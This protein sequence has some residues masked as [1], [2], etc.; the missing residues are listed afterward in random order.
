MLENFNLKYHRIDPRISTFTCRTLFRKDCRILKVMIFSIFASIATVLRQFSSWLI[1]QLYCSVLPDLNFFYIC[2]LPY[3]FIAVWTLKL[4]IW[5]FESVI[6]INSSIIRN[7]P[8]TC[9]IFYSC[10]IINTCL[11]GYRCLSQYLLVSTH[12]ILYVQTG[13]W[14]MFSH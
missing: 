11:V 3:F 4:S 7:S 1:F 8:S 12:C 10:H 13:L 6:N 14:Y 5:S 2:F 9:N